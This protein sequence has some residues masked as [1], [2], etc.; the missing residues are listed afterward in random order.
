MLYEV[1]TRVLLGELSIAAGKPVTLATIPASLLAEWERFGIDAVWLMGVWSSGPGG[2]AIARR[3]E[4]VRSACREALPD[5]TEGDIGG[6]PYAV[7]AYEIPD[8]FGGA[9][10]LAAL[11]ESLAE[12]GIGLVLD[13]VPNHTARDHAWVGAHPE[14]YVR[15]KERD[16]EERP[17]LFFRAAAGKGHITLAMGRDPSFAGWTDTAQLN[18]RHKGARRAMVQLLERIAGM[19]DGVRCDMAMLVLNSVFTRTWGELATPE[20]EDPAG[21]EFWKEAISAVRARYPEH[22]FIAEAYWNM[23]WE[24][25]QLGF[26]YTYDK[27]L[28]DR[29]LREGAG[30]VRDHL[31]A[32]IEYQKHSLRFIENHDEP[33]AASSLSSEPW[34]YAASTVIATVPG[35]VMF[36]EGQFEGRRAKLPVQLTRRPAEDVATRT[37]AFY[38]KLLNVIASP[39]FKEG[40]WRLLMPRAA[41]HENYTW[42]NFLVF[43]WHLPSAGGGTRLVV[44][45]YAPLSGQCYVDIP[46]EDLPGGSIEFRDL[47]SPAAYTRDRNGLASRGLYFD[48]EPYGIHIFEVSSAT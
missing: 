33:R 7:H 8:S 23:E 32:E 37:K 47:M 40:S 6:S 9:K 2:V 13:F 29:L 39:S 24:L 10:A 43:W 18:V 15:G 20:G 34:L 1:N 36:H 44:I 28:Y 27:T 5:F 16:A 4:G 41:W 26:D 19:C 31:R 42:G 12:R 21:E 25:Q 17:D 35:M 22:L 48:I 11:R 38:K 30:S 14:Y 3:D 46:L 45:N